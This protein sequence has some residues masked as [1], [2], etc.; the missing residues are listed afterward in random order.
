MTRDQ[1]PS[2]SLSFPIS[3]VGGHPWYHLPKSLPKRRRG[4]S[5]QRWGPMRVPF[6]GQ[7]GSRLRPHN[8]PA[9]ASEPSRLLTSFRARGV[10]AAER[11]RERLSLLV[12]YFRAYLYMD[13][14]A[15]TH[16]HARTHART[17]L[18]RGKKEI[19][20]LTMFEKETRGEKEQRR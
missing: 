15:L 5:V 18:K 17:P 16:A 20:K 19:S 2:P 14:L 10:T 4:A 11:E 13:G 12:L 6:L 1:I 8:L 7:V 3:T 9:A